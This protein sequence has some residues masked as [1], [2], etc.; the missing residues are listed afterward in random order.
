MSIPS[1]TH[2]ALELV[3]LSDVM[4]MLQDKCLPTEEELL[5]CRRICR[6]GPLSSRAQKYKLVHFPLKRQFIK[7]LI[8]RGGNEMR[9]FILQDHYVHGD[10]FADEILGFEEHELLV[11]SCYDPPS[12][13]KEYD[14]F[15]YSYA[16]LTMK[17][18]LAYD[19]MLKQFTR[20]MQFG[21]MYAKARLEAHQPWRSSFS[22]YPRQ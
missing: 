20:E 18:D 3:P 21:I 11:R 12:W 5:M 1:L 4:L 19:I 17:N 7:R 15:I 2:L 22:S 13:T 14:N 16:A 8:K 6:E 9:W 10:C